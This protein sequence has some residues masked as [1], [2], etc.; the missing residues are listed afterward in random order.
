MNILIYGAGAL[1]QALGC[2]LAV[3]AH[4]VDLVL[5]KRF[6]KVISE[7]G[8]SVSGVFGDYRVQPA[9]LGL[10]LDAA[11]V[12]RSYDYAF[13]TTKSYD[14]TNAVRELAGLGDRL[15]TVVS[16]QNGCGNVE[17]LVE[18]FGERR[19][20]GAR[21]ITGFEITS[22]GTVNIT[23]SADA[24]HIGAVKP[25]EDEVAENAEKLA[26]IFTEAGHPAVA[27]QD[28]Y[29]SLYAKL[30]YNCTL[31]PLGAVLGVHYG[32]LG[33]RQETRDVMNTVIDETFA[34]IKGLGGSTDWE[35]SD[36]YKEVFYNTLVPATY[37]HRPS[38]LQD[39]ENGKPTEVDSLVGY[40]G[41]CGKQLSLPTPTCDVLTALV[42]FKEKQGK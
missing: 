39:I 26:K 24:I 35:S 33:E 16:L 42:K 6:F 30:L 17:K 14:T 25:I 10:F 8:L 19:S 28:I 21:V 20:L 23:V 13:I 27:V 22:P 2:M 29:R 9:Q 7:K 4:N 5:R 12:T 34:V 37:N 36:A 31:N 11:E 38:M 3:A 41:N 18:A 1:G 32:A 15:Q 40:V